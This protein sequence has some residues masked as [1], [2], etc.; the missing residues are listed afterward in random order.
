MADGR[1][2]AYAGLTF[3]IVGTITGNVGDSLIRPHVT[4]GSVVS[5][6]YWPVALFLAVEVS[7]RVQ[8]FGKAWR[9]LRLGGL[10]PVAL[11]AAY[12]SYLHLSALLAWL[13]ESRFG[14]AV[15]PLS[16]DGLMVMCTGALI[17]SS[18]PSQSNVVVMPVP[19]MHNSNGHQNGD[20]GTKARQL[21][22]DEKLTPAEI[23]KRLGTTKHNVIT[24]LKGEVDA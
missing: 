5:A 10:G 3:G 24:W 4:A 13:G 14:A 6:V 12:V 1:G 21:S 20:I 22:N 23:A 19:E 11:I 15:G 2:W 18:R 16:I 8:L 7:A 9:W 17:L